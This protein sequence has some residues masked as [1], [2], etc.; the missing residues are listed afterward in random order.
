MLLKEPSLS[1]I[2]ASWN[3]GEQKFFHENWEDTSY[4]PAEWSWMVS[5]ASYWKSSMHGCDIQPRS[6]NSWWDWTCERVKGRAL[7]PIVNQLLALNVQTSSASLT[8]FLVAYQRE[9]TAHSKNELC[10]IVDHLSNKS[11]LTYLGP[12]GE[13]P[14]A[15][16]CAIGDPIVLRTLLSAYE[17]EGVAWDIPNAKQQGYWPLHFSVANTWSGGVK[18][19][20]KAGATLECLSHCGQT[21]AELAEEIGWS[22]YKK[23]EREGMG[24]ETSK[25]PLVKSKPANTSSKTEPL[26]MDL[27]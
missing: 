17:K 16:A 9:K 10:A 20:V 6:A 4:S 22:G 3:L 7:Q 18:E 14:L 11:S 5:D 27:F 21:P 1:D 8:T 2:S 26:Q 19:M 25:V 13:S 15:A 23:A 12:M 24:I